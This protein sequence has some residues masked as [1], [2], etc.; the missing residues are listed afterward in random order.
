MTSIAAIK[1]PEAAFLA[2][3]TAHLKHNGKVH[4]FGHKIG[5]FEA[6]KLA[7]AIQGSSGMLQLCHQALCERFIVF[8]QAELLRAI[9]DAL[10]EARRRQA[11]IVPQQEATGHNE[12][13]LWLAFW[14]EAFNCPKLASITTAPMA[15][16]PGQEPFTLYENDGMLSPAVD[17]SLIDQTQTDP[18]KL[19]AQIGQLQ[20]QSPH[21]ADFGIGCG[22][23]GS[24]ELVQITQDGLI[25]ET[26]HDFGDK[27]GRKLP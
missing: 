24:I 3:D 25:L 11:D 8:T 22:V 12:A 16:L 7:L 18:D 4:S 15:C 5:T 1:S 23:G 20:R 14:D 27:V 10:R 6:L 9:P 13:I 2:T 17:E 19:F 26:V 21:F